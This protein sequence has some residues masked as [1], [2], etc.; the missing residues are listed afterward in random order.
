MALHLEVA[1]IYTLLINVVVIPV[2]QPILAIPITWKKMK[3]IQITNKLIKLFPEPRIMHNLK[4]NSTKFT[5]LST[6]DLNKIII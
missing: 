4:S 5:E 2:H 1:M 6:H 3:N